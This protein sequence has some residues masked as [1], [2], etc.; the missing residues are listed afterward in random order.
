MA[1]DTVALATSNPDTA[2]PFAELG[3][4][5]DEYARIKEILGRRPTSSEL[6]MYS[7]MWSEHC[8]YKSSKVH[9]KQF[10]DKA[11]KSDALLVGIGENAG[12][13]DVGQGYAVTF[14]VESHNHPSF[15]EPYQ[16]A[17]TGVGGIVRDILTMGARPIAVMD[18]L[19]FGPADAP[20]TR[21]VLPGV[22]A[23]VGG[24]GNCLG[25]P[26]IG[27]EVVF[28]E[29]YLGNPLVNALCV[30][31]MKHSD[32]KLAKAAGAGNL[33]VLYGAKTGGDGIGGVSV[34]ASET[35][36]ATGPAKRPAVQ[37]GDPFVEK[38]L[39]E[40][41][42]EIFAEDLVI[43]I[44]DLGGA[45]LSCATSEL[46]SGGSGGM[47]V[48]LDRVPLRDATLSPEEILMSESQERMCAIVEPSKIN[49]FLEI[50]KKWDVT[51]TVIGEVTDGDRLEITW[52]GE[53]IVDVPPRTVAHDG[54]VYS[55][56]LAEPAYIARVNAE[57]INPVI[58]QSAQEIKAAILMM[59]AT[60]NL[61]DKSWV[62]N[63]YDRYV[64]GNTVQSQPDDSGMVRIDEKTHL[65]VA[66]ATDANANWSYLNP[67]EGAKLAL[68]EASRNIATAGAIPLAV[69]NCLNF[70][71]P[72]DPGVM[73][74]FAE[75]V[76][77]LADGC[78][79]MGL[80]VTGGNVS[81]YNQTGDVAILPTP[82][83]GVLGVI[84]DVRTRTPMSFDR[85]GLEL[86]LIGA[87]DENLSGSEWA[88]L[89]GMRGG[90][91]PTA[92]LQREMRLIKLLVKGRTEKIFSAAHDL[93]QGGL[94]ASLT[95][96]VLRHNVGATITLTNPG[97]NL[98][99]ETPGR[100]VV[101]VEVSK[102]AALKTAAGDIPLT[103]LGTTG[104]DAL[105]INDVKISLDELR[106]AHTST[107]QKLFG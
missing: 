11:V 10:G 70:G 73:W 7:V 39:I 53:L 21:R 90:Q 96:M 16:G 3:L 47:K 98:L 69:T 95:E 40:C 63:Q 74:Q 92:D 57:V 28:D 25:L 51:V 104:G 50:C 56:P 89:H 61:A 4:K 66:V 36:E 49:R 87:S 62:T 1:L 59:A 86:Y 77:G 6:A 67:Y 19:R 2:Q 100:V 84:D 83:I 46:A 82:V 106:T 22:I 31:V 43:G 44:Q 80:P 12:V 65:G 33:V 32:I 38:V 18:P 35:F 94:T 27:G 41:S 97:N 64:Q 42:L 68:A 58:P 5:G 8:S 17:A 105:V 30:G 99:V 81:F 48:E 37:V 93:S 78:L 101:A 88:Y 45:G 24:Y 54:P 34:L 79:E 20:D 23:G 26:N 15:I 55:R 72:E 60:P 91:A 52:H 107:F 71:S 29:T 103:Y 76:R 75:T 102:A 9:L 14:K 13:V 85:A